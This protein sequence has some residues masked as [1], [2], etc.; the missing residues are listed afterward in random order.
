MQQYRNRAARDIHVE[1][2]YHVLEDSNLSGLAYAADV[3]LK[4]TKKCL[5]G[6]RIEILQ[7][8][9][10]W[11]HDTD[12]NAPRV[13][14]LHGQAG[15]GKSAIAHTIALWSKDVGGLGTC[16]CFARDRMVEHLENKMFSTIARDL[17]NC[18]PTFRRALARAIEVDNT[19]Q[20]TSDVMQQWEKLLLGPLSMVSGRIVGNIVLVIDALDESG[21]HSAR[22]H[23]LSVLTSMQGTSLP[24]N[25]RILL[26]SRPLSDIMMALRGA[27]HVKAISLDDVGAIFTE[28]DIRLYVSK[29]V[30]G[31]GSIDAREIEHITLKADGLFEWAR[32]ACEFIRPSAGETSEERFANLMVH[33]SG[34]GATLLDGMYHSILESAVGRSLTALM[35]FRSTMQQILSTLEP[36]PMDALYAMRINFPHKHDCFNVAVILDSMGSLLSGVT[37]HTKPIRPLHASFYDF[38]TDQSRSRDY[39]VGASSIDAD[40]AI[41]SLYVLRGGL[42]FNICRLESSFL[43][44]S[45]VPD[46]AER[47]KAKIPPHLSYSCCFWAKHLW[48]TKFDPILAE[49]VKDILG[50]ERILF[51]LEAMSLLGV[52]GNAAAALSYAVRWLQ[53][54]R[55]VVWSVSL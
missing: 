31:F 52:L 16:F 1:V 33:A 39:F 14:W 29:M 22:E 12:V 34:E 28:R 46:L 7:E 37:D 55:S 5:D 21:D 18:D 53:V 51:W 15:K 40:L 32:L 20:T 6:T 50:N 42:S 3:G 19:L 23:I 11:I 48:A 13:F 4:A 45:E 36:L 9:V 38:L 43:L 30:K 54:S 8:I 2:V 41:A 17:A 26:T 47:V 35:R 27:R 10:D 49:Y 44:N 24:S 25:F